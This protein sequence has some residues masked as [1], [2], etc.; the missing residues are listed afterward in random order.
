MSEETTEAPATESTG[1]QHTTEVDGQPTEQTTT[2]VNGKY[3]SVSALEE[4]YQNL[5]KQ[6]GSFGGAPDEYSMGEGIEINGEH[7]LFADLQQFG[8]DSNLSNEGY[9]NLVNVLIESEKAS[10]AERQQEA[11]QV[12]KDL[13]ENGKERIQNVDDYLNANMELSEAQ[14]EMISLAKGMPGGVE[15]LESFIAMGK[16][17]SPAAPEIVSPTKT[18]TKEGLE[19]LRFELDNYGNRKSSSDP[20]HRA[21]VQEYATALQAQNG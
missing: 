2:Y 11:E 21:K 7:P 1:T 10:E 15:L 20:A 5:H 6:F 19:S 17:T 12:F 16:K 9:Q 13:G 4:G 3:N 18:Y 14:A 8:K